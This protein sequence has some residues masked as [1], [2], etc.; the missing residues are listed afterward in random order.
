MKELAQKKN[1]TE[2]ETMAQHNYDSYGLACGPQSAGLRL[3]SA[4]V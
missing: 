4:H 1:A 2:L 3:T